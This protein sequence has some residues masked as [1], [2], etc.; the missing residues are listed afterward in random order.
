MTISRR[1]FGTGSSL[2]AVLLL[3]LSD[4]RAIEL[5]NASYFCTVEF[6]G[7]LAFN[8]TLKKWGICQ[9]SSGQQ[10]HLEI[11]VFEKGDTESPYWRRRAFR[12]FQCNHHGSWY[13]QHKSVFSDGTCR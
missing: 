13:E 1:I 4:S 11:G 7:G 9:V 3:G 8:E 10:I 6:A 2:I 12:G 5:K